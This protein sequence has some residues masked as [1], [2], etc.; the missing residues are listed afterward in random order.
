MWGI[1]LILVFIF[2]V[3]LITFKHHSPKIAKNFKSELLLAI[4]CCV[5]FVWGS[6][7]I[8]IAFSE[9]EE[10]THFEDQ[11]LS[12]VNNFSTKSDLTLQADIIRPWRLK[13]KLDDIAGM[14]EAKQE[15]QQFI[16][17]IKIRRNLKSL[18][19]N[20]QRG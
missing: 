12:G 2:T 5:I 1:I 15:A 4:F 17:L 19:Q 13:T 7:K 11:S 14:T 10:I 18:V 16:D 20:R 3:L 6:Y 9:K 8:M